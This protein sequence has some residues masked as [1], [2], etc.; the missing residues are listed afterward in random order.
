MFLGFSKTMARFG[1]FRL[2]VG[3]RLTKKNAA[4]MA[5]ILMFVW[6]LQLCWYMMILCFW[7]IYAICYGIY[8]CIKSIIKKIKKS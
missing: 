2:G 8:W 3:M 4:Y 1:H 7:M 5:I 6:M